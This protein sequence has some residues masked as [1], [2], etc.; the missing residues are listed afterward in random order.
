[1][2][3]NVTSVLIYFCLLI[4]FFF[5]LCFFLKK[6]YTLPIS[7]C[8]S[9]KSLIINFWEKPYLAPMI[10]SYLNLVIAFLISRIWSLGFVHILNRF[11]YHFSAK[12]NSLS[13]VMCVSIDKLV[14]IS[15]PKYQCH[16]IKCKII[17]KKK[18]KKK[19]K[20]KRPQLQ[21]QKTIFFVILIF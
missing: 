14:F 5:F 3:L 20:M 15:I 11:L 6:N 10:L 12:M 9:W 4:D 16:I 21:K 1:M 2:I 7:L 13:Y 17:K 8:S 19:K 18:K